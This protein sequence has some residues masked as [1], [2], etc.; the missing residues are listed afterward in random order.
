[1]ESV[2]TLGAIL[3][4]PESLDDGAWIYLPEGEWSWSTSAAVLRSE[5]VSPERED[6]PDAGVPPLARERGLRKVL[7]VSVVQEIAFN[8]RDQKPCLDDRELLA[9]LEFYWRHDAF[10]QLRDAGGRP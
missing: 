1:M 10:I 4:S 8:A 2:T 7:P 5:E 9:A 6:E 3:S